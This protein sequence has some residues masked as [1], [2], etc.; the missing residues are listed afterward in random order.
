MLSV[1]TNILF[2]AMAENSQFHVEARNFVKAHVGDTEM[3]ISE[4]VLVELYNLLRNEKLTGRK[5]TATEAVAWIHQIRS[6]PAWGLVENAPVMT[7]VWK[8]AGKD[9]FARR[10]IFD[11]RLALT[12]RHHGI[13]QFATANLKDFKNCGF[14][15]VWNPLMK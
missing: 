15:K 5:S 10:R 8:I 7:E 4:L 14:E 2:Y 11:I 1:D 13:T 6:N 9:P 3:V 12:L